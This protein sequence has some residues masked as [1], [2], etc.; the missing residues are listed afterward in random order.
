MSARH[1]LTVSKVALANLVRPKLTGPGHKHRAV[2]GSI[3]RVHHGRWSPAAASYRYRWYVGTHRI[4]GATGPTLLVAASYQ[5]KRLSCVVRA[6]R[7][8]YLVGVAR[9]KRLTVKA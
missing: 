4:K 9:T 5:G 8:H 6:K 7:P 3:E 1:K 2:V